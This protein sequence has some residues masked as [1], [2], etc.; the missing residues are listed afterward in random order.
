MGNIFGRVYTCLSRF[1]LAVSHRMVLEHPI[2][3]NTYGSGKPAGRPTQERPAGDGVV[4]WRNEQ[5]TVGPGPT[6]P[7]AH[8]QMTT[9]RRRGETRDVTGPLPLSILAPP[10]TT[11]LA[12][13]SP[14]ASLTC[15][16]CYL[17]DTTLYGV[18]EI[19][20]LLGHLP[21]FAVATCYLGCY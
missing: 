10:V 4:V 8:H 18:S 17:G 2:L 20:S 1:A 12:S 7:P 13:Q 15:C 14:V 9:L 21:N 5:W 16:I 19:Q 3:E 6:S 11:H